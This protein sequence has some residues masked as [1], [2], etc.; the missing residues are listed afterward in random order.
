MTK[1]VDNT[2]L[3][4]ALNVI[5]TATTMH[6]CNAAPS[7]FAE[8]LSFSIGFVSVDTTDFSNSDGDVSGRKTTI[9]AQAGISV[10]QTSTVT[11]VALISSSTFLA[12]TEHTVLAVTSGDSR[13]SQAFD[14]EIRDPA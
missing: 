11:H 3:D 9:G 13:N 12:L 1:S 7:S 10:T 5:A 2:V 4:A 8:V 6:L 14:F